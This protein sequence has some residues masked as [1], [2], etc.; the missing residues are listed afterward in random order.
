MFWC[1]NRCSGKALR[2]WQFALAVVD[3][4]EEA[5]TINLV[6]QRKIDGTGPCAVEVLAVEG[7]GGKEGASWQTMENV[8]K[9]P[10]KTRN[11]GVFLSCKSESDGISKGC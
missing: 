6:L 9:R 11:V 3:D 10:A 4:G 8:G 5:N 7:S 1:D 2:F